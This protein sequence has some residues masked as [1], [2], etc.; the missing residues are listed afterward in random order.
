MGKKYCINKNIIINARPEQIFR[1][2]ADVE[3]WN[4]WT[5]SVKRITI[6]NDIKFNK[7][8]KVKVVQPKLLPAV[9][10]ITEI[11]KNKC[12]TWVT[13]YIGLKMTGKHIIETKNNVTNVELVMIYEGVLAKLFYRLTSS[14]TSQYL[15]M[16]IKGLKKECENRLRERKFKL[17]I[18]D[19]GFLT[20]NE[21]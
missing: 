6:I 4:L 3:N 17:L 21:N 10:E 11:E 14:L 16:E 9:W 8:T 13:K 20:V 18:D 5:S 15:T 2:L 7:G 12:F 19:V 1:V